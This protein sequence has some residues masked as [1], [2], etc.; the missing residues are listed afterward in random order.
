MTTAFEL[1]KDPAVVSPHLPHLGSVC[2]LS[3][4]KSSTPVCNHHLPPPPLIFNSILTQV[5]NYGKLLVDLSASVPDGIVCF[6]VSYLYMDQIIRCGMYCHGGVDCTVREV[7]Q[8][9]S[10]LYIPNSRLAPV[11]V[12]LSIE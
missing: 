2:L 11:A 9:E 3:C 4:F 1:R 10:C 8:F 5:C 12:L 7:H 6:F